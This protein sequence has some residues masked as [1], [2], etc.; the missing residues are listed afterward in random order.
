MF[1]AVRQ[2]PCVC[3]LQPRRDQEPD[4]LRERAGE[5]LRR[6]GCGGVEADERER[7]E[8]WWL[9]GRCCAVRGRVNTARRGGLGGNVV[10]L[11]RLVGGGSG[12]SFCKAAV[13]A[14]DNVGN[15]IRKVG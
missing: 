2:S 3:K 10:L 1:E 5:D 8:R 13:E 11:R 7:A 15:R 4:F 6:G 9:E 14:G 12:G